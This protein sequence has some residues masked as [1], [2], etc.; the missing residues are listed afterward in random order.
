MK[1]YLHLMLFFLLFLSFRNSLF[2]Q[3]ECVIV[4]QGTRQTPEEDFIRNSVDALVRAL[5][6][7]PGQTPTI[8]VLRPDGEQGK[9]GDVPPRTEQNYSDKDE[10]LQQLEAALCS[11]K[12]KNVVIATIGHGMGGAE[13]NDP[14]NDR[15]NGGL[16]VGS[17]TGTGDYLL[18]EE[19]AE[20]IDKCGKSVKL[21]A[22]ACYSESM[23]AG[24]LDKLKNKHLVGVGVSSSGW[25]EES[26]AI[27]A[28]DSTM[29]YEFIIKLL[30]DYYI[31][32]KDPNVMRELRKKA[33]ELKKVNEE[34]NKKLKEENKELEEKKR[35]CA[36]ELNKLK[37]EIEQVDKEIANVEK[38]I[39]A[40]QKKLEKA[41]KNQKKDIEKQISELQKKLEDL[42]KKKTE[43]AEKISDKEWECSELDDLAPWSLIP[44]HLPLMELI[45]HAAFESAKANTKTSTPR[46][47]VAP[48]TTHIPLPVT[49]LTGIQIGDYHFKFYKVLDTKANRCVVVG[50]QCT[51][52]GVPVQ[53]IN[54][55]D[56]SIDCSSIKFSIMEHGQEKIIEAI[57]G[58]DGKY[59]FTIDGKLGMAEY[60]FF[61]Q[62]LIVPGMLLEELY[63]S[64]GFG[65]I[66]NVH[67]TNTKVIDFQYN[68]PML[69]LVV[70]SKEE[71]FDIWV[72][73][74]EHEEVSIKIG[75]REPYLAS[76]TKRFTLLNENQCF[77]IAELGTI[78]RAG[79]VEATLLHPD[80]PQVTALEGIIAPDGYRFELYGRLGENGISIVPKSEEPFG[81]IWNWNGKTGRVLPDVQ[82]EPE[83]L[84]A[85][86]K[87]NPDDGLPYAHLEF[88]MG[89]LTEADLIGSHKIRIAHLRPDYYCESFFDVFVDISALGPIP[90]YLSGT[91]NTEENT[92]ANNY[93]GL[94]WI[95]GLNKNRAKYTVLEERY[96]TLE[97]S[98]PIKIIFPAPNM[99]ELVKSKPPYLSSVSD[100]N[101]TRINLPYPNPFSYWSD[102]RFYLSADTEVEFSL[103][104]LSGQT[105]KTFRSKFESGFHKIRISADDLKHPG[106]YFY[107][108]KTRY[109]VDAGKLVFKG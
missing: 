78:E 68:E 73:Y 34:N 108:F 65:T 67:V 61:N 95:Y 58:A 16:R 62:P 14:P 54:S 102:L 3:D 21:I 105:V 52:E 79:L 56:C 88:S 64:V 76:H 30:E 85:I 69:S 20:L 33:E 32:I 24:I 31:I 82:R 15:L 6:E 80:I 29:V 44:D 75:N 71:L 22:A 12:C 66:E 81:H 25:N 70:L 50:F 37:K 42:N 26:A 46:E 18:A 45:I 38:E 2:S 5:G 84:S 47:P 91:F 74:K 109:S 86:V 11:D 103:F 96:D 35:K 101:V 1:T 100:V 97:Y 53:G 43:L 51:E 23:I 36:E 89:Y 83:L 4:I 9:L 87:I 77:P 93:S 92:I 7:S 107:T 19:I 17:G 48:Q 90:L 41:K 39:A 106:V 55:K 94:Y 72:E 57:K 28:D 27:G 104:N 49:P 40:L 8:T 10:L 13:S 63:Y 60:N 99:K 98:R 59:S